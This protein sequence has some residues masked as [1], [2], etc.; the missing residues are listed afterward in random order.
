MNDSWGNIYQA[1]QQHYVLRSRRA[2][3]P[4]IDT[5]SM[6]PIGQRRSY[7]DV[8]INDGGYVLDAT[9]LRRFISFD[10]ETG[11]LR[12]EAGVTLWEV[13]RVIVPHGWFLPVTPGTSFVTVG[14]AVANDVH[15]KNHHIA[16]SFGCFVRRFELRRATGD[17]LECSPNEE[18]DYFAATIGGCGLT[19]LITWVEFSLKKIVNP[20]LQVESIAYHNYDEFLALSTE[21]ERSHEY[22][23]SW[24]DC[25]AS[26][27]HTGR[28]V[29][30]RANHIELPFDLEYSKKRS[31]RSVPEIIGKGF[32]LVNRFSLLAF[33]R[34]YMVQNSGRRTYTESFAK[35]FYPLDSLLD[36]NRIYGRRGFYQFQCVVPFESATAISD[37]L[38]EISRSGQGSFLSVLKT[39]GDSL[40]PGLI[41]FPRPGVTLALDFPNRGSKTLSLLERLE[42]MVVE[43][44]GAIYPAK[45]AVMSATTFRHCFP[46]LDKFSNYID[47]EFSS[48]FW[49]RV[50]P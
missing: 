35:Y 45:D 21:S 41:S 12:C 26:G 11:V 25:L 39:M 46:A 13:L 38:D 10:I 23:V 43:A 18:S 32:P 49:R 29:F 37:L 3:V 36:W 40:S 50:N 15:G 20:S 7:G 5:G 33:N 16:G 28:G 47:P 2:E 6:L 30:L 44:G 42:A 48:S 27:I 14:G 9:L 4:N 34:L 8:G 22:T 19:G 17:I 24:I 1:E 31:Q